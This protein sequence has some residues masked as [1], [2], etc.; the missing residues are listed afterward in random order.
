MTSALL[1]CDIWDDHW[2][3]TAASGTARIARRAAVLVSRF[4]SAGGVVIHA[5]CQTMAHYASHPARRYVLELAPGPAPVLGAHVDSPLPPSPGA[6]CPDSPPCPEPL[7]PPWPWTR[8]HPAI[9][10]TSDDAVLDQQDELFAV[11]ADRAIGEVYVAGVHTNL[12]VLDRPYGIK[13][14]VRAGISCALVAD[15]TEAMPPAYT[16][17]T[18]DYVARHWCRVVSSLEARPGIAA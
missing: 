16:P 10:V 5:P 7:G 14:M 8:Q 12:C 9:E 2:C 18:L 1:L 13:A 6:R 15:L 17:A 3:S 11:I 4:R